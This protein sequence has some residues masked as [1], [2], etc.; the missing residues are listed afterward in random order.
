MRL[1][2]TGGGELFV[3]EGRDKQ[4]VFSARLRLSDNSEKKNAVSHGRLLLQTSHT[5]SLPF[6]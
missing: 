6:E 5:V 4:L 2:L 1:Y 3:P